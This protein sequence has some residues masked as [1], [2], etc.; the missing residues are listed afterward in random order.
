LLRVQ[1]DWGRDKEQC[2]HTD[3]KQ[4][5]PAIGMSEFQVVLR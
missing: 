1:Q 2:P 5:A 3:C 4:T